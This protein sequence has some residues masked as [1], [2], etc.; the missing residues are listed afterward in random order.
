MVEPNTYGGTFSLPDTRAGHVAAVI[1]D[2]MYIIGGYNEPIVYLDDTWQFN[3]TAEV[4]T[5]K[6]T[7]GAIPEA[8][9]QSAMAVSEEGECVL[10]AGY[11]KKCKFV[12]DFQAIH[13][14]TS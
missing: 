6:I 12:F 2:L 8:R 13:L 5:K 3:M 1:G 11:S 14:T 10:F 4:W 7:E 9:A